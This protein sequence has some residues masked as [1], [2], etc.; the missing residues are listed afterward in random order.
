MWI[1]PFIIFFFFSGDRLIIETAR[2][3][4]VEDIQKLLNLTFLNPLTSG[5]IINSP[6]LNPDI[7]L[8]LAAQCGNLPV[9]KFMLENGADI[10]GNYKETLEDFN[11]NALE[12]FNSNSPL[13][14]ATKQ[15]TVH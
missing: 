14:L 1:T 13:L 15:G 5:I 12:L 10:D 4:T 8:R 2:Y 6:L 3:G 11:W 7:L 9:V